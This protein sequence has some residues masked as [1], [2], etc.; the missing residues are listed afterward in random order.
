MKSEAAWLVSGVVQFFIRHWGYALLNPLWC[1]SLSNVLQA[2]IIFLA[3]QRKAWLP[4]SASERLSTHCQCWLV[5]SRYEKAEMDSYIHSLCKLRRTCKIYKRVYN[6]N[7]KERMS[8]ANC[9]NS[10]L[11]NVSSPF[12]SLRSVNKLMCSLRC[13][14]CSVCVGCEF[15]PDKS[16]SEIQTFVKFSE[17]QHL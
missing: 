3:L 16:E 8:E 15:V 1:A 17:R 14:T 7:K 4:Y 11:L 13:I 9:G 10:N 6:N 5:R 2:K 12:S